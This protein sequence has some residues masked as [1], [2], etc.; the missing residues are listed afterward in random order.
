M[1][2][3]KVLFF[4]EA[5]TAAHLL[6]TLPLAESLA[7]QARV[8]LAV[9]DPLPNLIQKFSGIEFRPLSSTVPTKLFLEALYQGFLPYDES[10]L[11]QQM[12]EDQVLV[13]QIKPDLVV[14]DFRLSACLRVA[15]LGIPIIN[16][17]NAFWSPD[18]E[19]RSPLPDVPFSRALGPSLRE[20]FDKIFWKSSPVM[21]TL[22]FRKILKPFN[23]LRREL[24]LPPF[25]RLQDLYS[26]GDFLVHPDPLE[27]FEGGQN[28]S[29]LFL[30]PITGLPA[31]EKPRWLEKLDPRRK[32]IYVSMGSSGQTEKLKGLLPEL[33]RSPYQWI[34]ISKDE[35]IQKLKA[36]NIFTDQFVSLPELAP[37]IDFAVLNGG[38]A[39]GYFFLSQGIPFLGIPTNMDQHLFSQMVTQRGLAI[40]IRSEDLKIESLKEL[41]EKGLQDQELRRRCQEFA[42]ILRKYHPT[43]SFCKLVEG[44]F[45]KASFPLVKE[46]VAK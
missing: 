10:R 13:D 12:A 17:Q 11:R 34:L 2:D 22:V 4:V 35:E 29:S 16:L 36:E 23:K 44:F 7:S 41:I 15:A 32:T 40:S 1:R 31:A 9:L 21:E 38:S 33:T 42:Q 8:F 5:V 46:G 19:I 25:S 18:Y 30:G 37:W 14:I 24:N 45:N 27:L 26:F 6:R 43:K 39:Q 3:K 20:V 28:W